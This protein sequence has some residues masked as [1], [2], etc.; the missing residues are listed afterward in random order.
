MNSRSLVVLP[1][2]A[3]VAACAPVAT[4]TPPDGRPRVVATTDE[5]VF[6][7]YDDPASRTLVLNAS[8]ESAFVALKSLYPI[9][10]VEV[11]H[12]DPA[13]GEVGNRNLSIVRRLGDRPLS[14]YVN[15]GNTMM[16]L[17]ADSYRLRMSVVSR[18]TPRGTGSTVLTLL[19]ASGEDMTASKGVVECSTLGVFESKLH[20]YVLT[21]TGG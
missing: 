19:T 1:I 11:K 8:P 4:S 17:A 16:G 14:D 6:R 21:R 13:S 20:E 12:A 7:A 9:L 5:R 10:G 2:L 15:C 18:V 3:F